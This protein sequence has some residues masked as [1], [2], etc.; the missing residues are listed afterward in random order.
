MAEYKLEKNVSKGICPH[1]QHKGK[2]R[3]FVGFHGDSRYGICD[4]VNN[5]PSKGTIYFPDEKEMPSNYIKPES[6]KAKKV[7][8]FLNQEEVA[9][10]M[11]KTD[12]CFHKYCHNE[13]IPLSHL[14]KWN[15]GGKDQETYFVFQDIQG[16]YVNAKHG[17]YDMHGNRNKEKGFKSLWSKEGH[18]G[19]CIYG[20][21]L[22]TKNII[23]MVESEKTAVIASLYYPQYDWGACGSA[24]GLSDGSDD[25]NDKISILKGKFVKWICDADK[26]GRNNSS[27][28]NME[29]HKIKHQIIDLFPLRDD[30]YD[31]AD[32]IRDNRERLPKI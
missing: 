6:I 19:L 25:T 21:H 24:N 3:Y 10:I 20:E 5:C 29:K 22:W 12:T 4:R 2:W 16:R 14:I 1:C 26:A 18:Y 8:L 28:N 11:Q 17:L 9:I 15:I 30:G 27:I 23:Y 7:Q 31:I 13:G 32:R